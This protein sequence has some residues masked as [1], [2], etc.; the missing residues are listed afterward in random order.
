MSLGTILLIILVLLLLGAPAGVA[1][2]HGLG[3]LPER[4]AGHSSHR[5][6]GLG[7]FRTRV[8]RL[9]LMCNRRL[10]S[11]AETRWAS[12]VRA[13]AAFRQRSSSGG[14]DAIRERRRLSRLSTAVR[15]DL[16]RAASRAAR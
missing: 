10:V 1:I 7:Y 3:L 5:C 12:R 6:L 11:R 14:G 4:R 9:L 15:Q 16:D 8:R 2:Q 13:A